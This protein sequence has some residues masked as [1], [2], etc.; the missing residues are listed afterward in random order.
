M[1][2]DFK[3]L[4][5]ELANTDKTNMLTEEELDIIRNQMRGYLGDLAKV[6]NNIHILL[7]SKNSIPEHTDYTDSLDKLIIQACDIEEKIEFLKNNVKK[8]RIKKYCILWCG[9][10]KSFKRSGRCKKKTRNVHWRH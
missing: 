9:L 7:K 3:A 6:K 4:A 1:T 8:F 2:I 5:V 10:D